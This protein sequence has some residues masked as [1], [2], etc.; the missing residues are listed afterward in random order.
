MDR[1]LELLAP[2]QNFNFG[3]AAINHGA[4][5][6]YIGAP[7]FGAR[8]SAGN[9]VSD[10][11]RLAQYAHIYRARVY[12]T[13]NT[14]LFD[15]EL[16]EA[17][18]IIGQLYN[19]G[20]DAL[21]I[22]D[23]GLLELDLPPL[24]L[25]ASTQCHNACAGKVS[26]LEKVGFKRAVLARELSIQEIKGIRSKTNIELET[27]I[28]GALCVCYSGQC[29]MSCA[30]ADRSGNRGVCSQPCRSSYDLF[31][32]DGE[33]LK[34]DL[35][36]LSLKDLNASKQLPELIAAGV[37]SF[38]I[39]GR[40]KG[41]P[42]LKNITSYYRVLFDNFIENN[43]GYSK[44][45]SG[46]TTFFFTPDPEKTFNRSYTSYFL[47]GRTEKVALLQ[48][49]KSIG[50]K[51]GEVKEVF[52]DGSFLL[53]KSLELKN[54]DGLCFFN[55]IS[56]LEGFLINKTEMG[57][58]F[59]NRKVLLRKKDIVY[60]NYDSEFEK[61]LMRETSAKRK[62]DVSLELSEIENGFSLRVTDEDNISVKVELMCDKIIAQKQDEY[63]SNIIKQLS[64]S[65]E[66]PFNITFVSI[67]LANAYFLPIS[68]LNELRRKTLQK[69]QDERIRRFRPTP[70]L[71]EKNNYPYFQTQ[72]DYKANIINEK[73]V[74]FYKRHGVENFEYGLEKE[75]KSFPVL[76]TTKHC[77]KYQL[78]QCPLYFSQSMAFSKPLILKNNAKTYALEFDCKKCVMLITM[79]RKRI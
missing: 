21:I 10:I 30:I 67:L 18:K 39:E 3:K 17:E 70:I 73:A 15:K 79:N 36:L 23:M 24:A 58:I 11:E 40:L 53:D 5:A 74:A 65:G 1:T 26:F 49:Q 8:A 77:I 50:K 22:Q 44:S 46:K 45:S 38:K 25:H 57:R 20:I 13:L 27:F 2:A 12:V 6:V 4:D 62:V 47:N 32:S 54:G 7:R 9:S 64:K 71:F 51:M 68:L 29:Y 48:T 28:H 69:L 59:P 19:A 55:E 42:Y 14:L 78:G 33:L 34:K 16:E 35:H 72:L 37:K 76:M 63:K 56:K 43:N 31:N 61:Q 60:R 75:N 66:S 52:P 41:L